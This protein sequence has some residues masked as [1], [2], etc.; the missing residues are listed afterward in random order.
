MR[1]HKASRQRPS[2]TRDQVPV[3]RDIVDHAIKVFSHGCATPNAHAQLHQRGRRQY[4]ILNPVV[5]HTKMVDPYQ[6]PRSPA[7]RQALPYA[8]P[9]I[10]VSM[11]GRVFQSHNRLRQ[12]FIV[13]QSRCK[14]SGRQSSICASRS[15][16]LTMSV[17]SF[18][19]K[20]CETAGPNTMSP[21]MPAVRFKNHI[22]IW[23][24]ADAVS[25]FRGMELSGSREE[26]R[27]SGSRTGQMQNRCSGLAAAMAELAICF[28]GC[29]EHGASE[30]WLPARSGH[31]AG[32]KKHQNGS[33]GRGQS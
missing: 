25:H 33:C 24:S 21:P 7:S 13:P 32:D 14:I 1:P 23:Q 5:S 10:V 30:S 18:S 8:R 26:H 15:S 4:T 12:K 29:V 31:G 2:K 27:F 19:G 17:A 6:R 3:G 16:A 22:D 20:W 11:P 9:Q 28:P